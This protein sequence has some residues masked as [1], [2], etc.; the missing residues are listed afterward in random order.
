[1]RI[2]SVHAQEILDSRARPTLRVTVSLDQGARGT[3]SVPSGAS[4][5]TAEAHELRDDDGHMSRAMRAIE[6]E[7]SE[8]LAGREADDQR[9]IDEALI[10]LDGTPQKTR[11]GG[12]ALI[13]VSVAIAKA[14]AA[15]QNVPL[16]RYLQT[17]HNV[18]SVAPGSPFLYMNLIN[19]GLH[20]RTRLAFQE[21]MIVPDTHSP[22]QAL[23]T[24]HEVMHR[25]DGILGQEKA[26]QIGD[27]GGIALDTADVEEPIRI[28]HAIRG[29]IASSHPFHIA[30]D[31]AASSFFENGSYRVGGELMAKNEY[32][33]HI[34]SLARTYE[35]LSIEDP[36]EENDFA[37]FADLQKELPDVRIVGD[38]LTTTNIDRLRRA[39]SAQSIQALIIK[40]NQIGTLTET[41]DTMR[42]ARENGID[43]IVSHRSAETDDNFIADLAHGCGS[44]GI[45]AG[46]PRKPERLSKI[47]RLIELEYNDAS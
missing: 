12:N 39:V 43:C 6:T 16:H 22:T 19:G 40:P 14:A 13:G 41:I 7:I 24:A 2:A 25:I 31:I 17:L 5:G 3:F 18:P 37:G 29:E 26:S 4:T 8:A 1:M 10:A 23:Q 30:L 44:Y 15:G 38:D 27:E 46:A 42:F 9:G 34:T 36:F 21:F 28:L 47:N 45:K 35:L 20:A 32:A 11:L 33:S